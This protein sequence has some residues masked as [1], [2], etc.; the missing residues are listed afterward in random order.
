VQKEMWNYVNSLDGHIEFVTLPNGEQRLDPRNSYG[1]KAREYMALDSDPNEFI[2]T[3]TR[4]KERVKKPVSQPTPPSS[5]QSRTVATK[6][7]VLEGGGG[8]APA[9][10]AETRKKAIASL[11]SRALQGDF[12]AA[13]KLYDLIQSR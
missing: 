9:P 3:Y 7:P 10:S 2:A 11:R 6:A 12:A 4:I 5:V 13:G 8:D 1:P